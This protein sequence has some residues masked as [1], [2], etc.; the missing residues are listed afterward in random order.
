MT[1]DLTCTGAA[2][3]VEEGQKSFPSGHT[4]CEGGRE[5]GREGKDEDIRIG[6]EDNVT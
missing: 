5:G 3:V 2:G 6:G 1:S 4:G